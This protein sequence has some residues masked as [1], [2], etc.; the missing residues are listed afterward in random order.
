RSPDAGTTWASLNKGLCITEIEFLT[1][2]PD[3]DAWLLAGTQDNGTIRYEGQQTWYQV[4]DGDGGACGVD[5]TNPATCY[6]SFCGAYLEKASKGGGWASWDSTVPDDLADEKS[7]FYPPLEVNGSLV[8]RAATQI[9]I[10]RDS[11]STWNPFSL[12]G[13]TGYPSAL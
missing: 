8:V 6:H 4:Q 13:L 10:S 11:G 1:Q 9:W 12:P 3:F 2:H 5:G 7:L